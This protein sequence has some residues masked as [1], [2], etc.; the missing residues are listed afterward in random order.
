M[1]Q[2]YARTGRNRIIQVHS[3]RPQPV[4][5]MTSY[6]LEGIGLKGKPAFITPRSPVQARPP[7]PMSPTNSYT[8]TEV[9]RSAGKRW[10]RFQSSLD[11]ATE[12]AILRTDE[13]DRFPALS[14]KHPHSNPPS[15]IERWCANQVVQF[16]FR[17][18]RL[19]FKHLSWLVEVN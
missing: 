4:T 16:Y 13:V 3:Q 2:E 9:P 15:Q 7:L 18:R 12:E 8:S 19:K 5:K 11:L 1:G 14:G 17:N 10:E 6:K